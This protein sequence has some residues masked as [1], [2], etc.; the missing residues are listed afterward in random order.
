MQITLGNCSPFSTMGREDTYQGVPFLLKDL[1][2]TAIPGVQTRQGAVLFQDF[3][4]A[5]EAEIVTRYRRAGFVLIGKTAT[6]ELGLAPT[7][8]SRLYGVTRNPWDV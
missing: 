5:Y 2:F 6:P 4:P 3:V 7:T 8:E 1:A